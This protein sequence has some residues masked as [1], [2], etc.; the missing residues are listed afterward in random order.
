VPKKLD[1]LKRVQ[2]TWVHFYFAFAIYTYYD[3]KLILGRSQHCDMRTMD[4]CCDCICV[5][6]VNQCQSSASFDHLTTAALE[7]LPDR[8]PYSNTNAGGIGNRI[9]QAFGN[10]FRND[11]FQNDDSTGLNFRIHQICVYVYV[12]VCICV[13][14]Y[15]CVYACLCLCLFL[16]LC[17][18][19]CITQSAR[20]VHNTEIFSHFINT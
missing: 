5:V 2:N 12:C 1:W 10:S 7:Q 16:C 19:Q 13:Y 17:Q 20:N 6:G 4:V 11:G 15:V 14:V 8:L 3:C 18:C 9:D